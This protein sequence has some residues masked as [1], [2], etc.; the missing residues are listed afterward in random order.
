MFEK[1]IY[2]VYIWRGNII[3]GLDDGGRVSIKNKFLPYILDIFIL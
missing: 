2:D 3:Y 1:L